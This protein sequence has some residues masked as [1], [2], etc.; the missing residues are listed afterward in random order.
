MHWVKKWQWAQHS[1]REKKIPFDR[2]SVW[3]NNNRRDAI[4]TIEKEKHRMEQEWEKNYKFKIETGSLAKKIYFWKRSIWKKKTAKSNV[5]GLALAV[6]LNKVAVDQSR[7]LMFDLDDKNKAQ[8]ESEEGECGS[9]NQIFGRLES[10]CSQNF[11]FCVS[12]II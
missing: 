2:S 4:D 10:L 5:V 12:K 7:K 8:K 6:W 9:W 3:S 11:S 1:I